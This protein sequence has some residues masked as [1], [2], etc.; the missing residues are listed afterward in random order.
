MPRKPV[1]GEQSVWT[2]RSGVDLTSNMR[3]AVELFGSQ[4]VTAGTATANTVSNFIIGIQSP[5]I[6]DSGTDA[7]IR[8]VLF[9]PAEA[10]AGAAF[11]A[12]ALLTAQTN[13][14]KVI[15]AG[16]ATSQ[17]IIG[18]AMESASNDSEVVTIFV[19]PSRILL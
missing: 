11:T 3:R 17:R 1:S 19:L 13:T 9:G 7:S 14:S 15:E 6:P 16:S 8:V 2:Y 10:I 18:W 4:T 5:E 12:G